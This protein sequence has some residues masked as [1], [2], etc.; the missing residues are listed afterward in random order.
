MRVVEISLISI[1]IGALLLK[2]FN[3]SYSS[4]LA[5][6]ILFG[7]S[8]IYMIGGFFLFKEKNQYPAISILT[9]FVFGVSLIGI[10]FKIHSWPFANEMLRITVIP[11]CILFT[12]TAILYFQNKNN[13]AIDEY[14]RVLDKKNSLIDEPKNKKVY[15]GKMVL[16]LSGMLL[17]AGGLLWCDTNTIYNFIH[18]ADPEAVRLHTLW[19]NNPERLDY[20]DSL[21]QHRM[22]KE[23]N[24]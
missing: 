18:R 20:R 8:P 3:V 22:S 1:V 7:L 13:H 14:E 23:I 9:G 16:R 24:R 2:V 19:T 12:V 21:K 10:L 15:C 6:I 5:T 11:F 4:E 17:L